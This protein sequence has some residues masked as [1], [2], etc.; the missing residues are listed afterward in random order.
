MRNASSPRRG[1]SSLNRW[2]GFLV[3]LL[4]AM[5]LS[6]TVAVRPG[7]GIGIRDVTPDLTAYTHARI[8]TAPG[9]VIESGTVVVEG[10]VIRSVRSGSSVPAGAREVDLSGRTLYPGFIELVAH[11]G[12][13]EDGEATG[14]RH[15]YSSVRAE[16]DPAADY[17]PDPEANAELRGLGFSA[18]L[19]TYGDRIFRGGGAVVALGDGEAGDMIIADDVGQHVTLAPNDFQ[20]GQEEPTEYPTSLMGA[21]ALIRQTFLDAGWYQ[22]ANAYSDRNHGADRPQYNPALAALAGAASGADRVFMTAVDELDVRRALALRSEFSLSMVVVGNGYEY[23][24]PDALRRETV[25]L[26]LGFPEAPAVEDP[27][28]VLD[29]SLEALSH[30][31]LAPTNPA[32]MA[33]VGAAF[34]IS[35]SAG[36]DNFWGDLRSAI[37]AGLTP[38]QALA[39]LTTAPATLAGVSD[40][41][42]TIAEGKLAHFII[43]DGDLFTDGSVQAVVVDGVDY[44]ND[45]WPA[46]EPLGTWAVSYQQG[47]GPATFMVTG[48]PGRYEL[49]AGGDAAIR[50]SGSVVSM[51]AEAARFGGGEGRARLSA[52]LEGDQM[53]GTAALPDGTAFTFLASRTAPAVAAEAD[54]EETAV[55]S[56]LHR[57]SGYPAGAYTQAALPE[58]PAVLL[59]QNATVWTSAD[60]GI[61]DDTDILVRAGRIAEIGRDLAVPRGAMVIDAAG[62]HVTPGLIDAHSHTAMS[63]GTN[64]AT[65]SVTVEVRVRDII[66]PTDISIYRQIAGGT[67]AANVMH[68][69]ANAMGGQ[70]QTIKLRWGGAASDMIQA[71][72]QQGVKFA[73]GENVKQSNWGDTYTSRYPQTRMGV[74]EI[75]ADTFEAAREYRDALARRDGPPVRR[76]LRLEAALEILDGERQ[77]HIHSYRQDEIL[78]FARLAEQYH[79][80]VAAFQHVLEGYKVATEIA[81]LGAGASTFSDW[82]AYK[83]EVVD[84]IPYNG[85]LMYEQGVLVTFNSDDDE[86]ARRLNTEAAKAV[87]YGGVPRADA[88]DFV[89]INAAIQLGIDH[90]TGS[91]EVGKDADLVIWS[92]DPLSTYSIAEQTWIDGRRY[93]DLE[94]DRAM[95]AQIAAERARLIAMALPERLAELSVE[96]PGADDAEEV[97]LYACGDYQRGLYGDGRSTHDCAEEV[98]R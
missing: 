88:L 45:A 49:D 30:W 89:T 76:D 43:A 4:I 90:R 6:A 13:P 31:E 70:V 68:G 84:A 26:P 32:V 16:R 85:A 22:R 1:L 54:A 97:P 33:E 41:L 95:R 23:R 92:G 28:G 55:A 15:P 86:L 67:M 3:G 80:N 62:R 17:S 91:I 37:A 25:I 65:D 29:V 93:F 75:M 36:A 7:A 44:R 72:A 50:T 46:D 56:E 60:A 9:R 82:W 87:R 78:R 38:D 66:D 11:L 24:S 2:S 51:F 69:S 74:P 21:I 52:V 19:V 14:P 42:G 98:L 53:T 71:D 81:A 61:L 79:L 10:G 12:L 96:V 83:Y 27:D 73:L 48:G 64:E 5:P 57:F 58:Q 94:H 77:V 35:S 20:F 59:I 34:A 47:S 63:G 18:A 40:R 8:V 39:A